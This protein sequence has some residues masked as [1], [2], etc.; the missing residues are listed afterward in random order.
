MYDMH[1]R[2][3]SWNVNKYRQTEKENQILF[4]YE[5]VDKTLKCTFVRTGSKENAQNINKHNN[6]NNN[7]NNNNNNE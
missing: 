5:K 1:V 3:T 6:N 2:C 7:E 4:S